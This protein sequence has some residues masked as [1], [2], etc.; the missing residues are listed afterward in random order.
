MKRPVWSRFVV[1]ASSLWLVVVLSEPAAL[2]ACAMHDTT[3]GSQHAHGSPETSHGQ[4]HAH[5]S[6]G[7]R[8]P[9]QQ[10]TCIGACCSVVTTSLAPRVDLLAS[11]EALTVTRR[12]A[13][14][15][16]DFRPSAVEYARPPSVGPPTL[17]A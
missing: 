10:C 12:A 5:G 6:D 13:P 9:Q 16:I 3:H 1:V 14:P 15:A 11:V 2:H 8:T 7:T 17:T 4:Q